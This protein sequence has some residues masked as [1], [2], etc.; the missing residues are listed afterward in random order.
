MLQTARATPPTTNAT[1]RLL[2]VLR[3][4]R[5]LGGVS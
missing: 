2:P 4:A 1:A 3:D 5:S